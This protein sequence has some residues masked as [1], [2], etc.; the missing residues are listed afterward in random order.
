MK[1]C[2]AL[3]LLPALAAAE[4]P[5]L[6][7]YA[8]HYRMIGRDAAGL[9]DM[10]LRLDPSGADLRVTMCGLADAGL[11]TMPGPLTD[12]HY[13]EGRIGPY[14]VVCDPFSTYENYPL[15]A[16]YAEDGARLTLWPGDDFGAS[17]DCAP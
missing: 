11:L 6:D 4:S 2:I 1:L 16:C 12:E 17:L 13:I 10:P 15:L 3:V 14:N 8:G 5:P 9:V 7:F